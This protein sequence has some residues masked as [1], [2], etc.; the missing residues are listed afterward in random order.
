[1]FISQQRRQLEFHYTS[2]KHK[3]QESKVE[4]AKNVVQH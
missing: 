1:M 2:A 4:I 3:E